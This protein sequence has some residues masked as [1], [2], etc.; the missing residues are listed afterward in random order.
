MAMILQFPIQQAPIS[1]NREL[2]ARYNLSGPRYTSYPTALQF[3]EDFRKADY[4]QA[5]AQ[6]DPKAPLSIYIHIP[7]CAT[8]C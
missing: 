3:T 2:I 6:T 1:I 5:I 7:F 8:L 4:Q